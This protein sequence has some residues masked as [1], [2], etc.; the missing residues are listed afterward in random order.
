V[1]LFD[2]NGNFISAIQKDVR[3]QLK[4]A[5]LRAW[6]QSGIPAFPPPPISK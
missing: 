4:D 5:T 6:I 3:M 2:Q 1:G